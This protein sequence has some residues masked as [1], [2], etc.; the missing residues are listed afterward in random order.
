[1]KR[2]EQVMHIISAFLILAMGLL[3][4][5]DVTSRYLFNR[6]VQGTLEVV[7]FAMVA[8]VFLALSET[9]AQDAHIRVS[10]LWE[11]TRGATRSLLNLLGLIIGLAVLILIV[12][13]GGLTAWEAWTGDYVTMGTPPLPEWPA[14]AFIPLGAFVAGIRIILSIWKESRS[15]GKSSV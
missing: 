10:L 3:V 4:F 5:W 13:R 2:L 12:W 15:F 11:R 1:M 8:I 7:E 14:K 9:H 6:P